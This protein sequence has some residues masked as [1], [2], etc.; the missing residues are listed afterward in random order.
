MKAQRKIKE[1][2]CFFFILVFLALFGFGGE[3]SAD[4]PTPER[5]VEN[6]YTVILLM[7][8][9]GEQMRLR[10]IFKDVETGKNITSPV[11][12]RLSIAEDSSR[13]ILLAGKETQTL[14]GI[15]EFPYKFPSGGLYKVE[16]KFEANEGKIHQPDAWALWVPGQKKNLFQRYPIGIAEIGGFLLFLAAAGTAIFS[17]WYKRAKRK[18]LEISLFGILDDRD[19]LNRRISAIK[20]GKQKYSHKT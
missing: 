13:K 16:L 9:E 1:D 7:F 4:H 10:F 5:V 12:I 3:T 17:V 18:Y 11:K 8:P 20:Q 19:G 6:K 2:F 14:N 15:I